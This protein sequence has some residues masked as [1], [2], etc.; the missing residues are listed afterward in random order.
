MAAGLGIVVCKCTFLVLAVFWLGSVPADFSCHRGKLRDTVL[1]WHDELPEED[2]KKAE[3]HSNKADLSLCL[4]TTLQIIPAGNLPLYAKK[5]HGKLVICNLQPT[6]HVRAAYIVDIVAEIYFL[7]IVLL[8]AY[9][10]P[11]RIL[12]WLLNCFEWKSVLLY[13]IAGVCGFTHISLV[14]LAQALSD[15]L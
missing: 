2:A 9:Y 3:Y 13:I 15:V 12:F 10:N 1:D 8:L 7:L 5:N 6:K 11:M 4:G 14:L